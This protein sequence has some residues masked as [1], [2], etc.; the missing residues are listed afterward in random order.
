MLTV[1]DGYT[2]AD[3]KL[4]P[5]QYP[6]YRVDPVTN[7]PV[8]LEVIEFAAYCER[9]F[10]CVSAPVGIG[11]MLIAI[12]LAKLTGLRTCVVVPYKGL[13]K[14]YLDELAGHLTGIRG[15]SN[16]QCGDYAN[17]DCKSGAS[18]GCRY[19]S[20]NGVGGG[21]CEYER[22][23]E[24]ARNANVVVT[25]YDYWLNKN[26]HGGG[27][28]RKQTGED[29]GDANPFELLILDE[30]DEAEGKV[31][32]WLACR[33][34]ENEIKR[35]VKPQD[36]GDDIGVWR[37]FAKDHVE[38][39]TEDVRVAS[40]MLMQL[41]RK[42]T[43]QQVDGLHG[44][45]KLQGKLERIAGMQDDWV[46][47]ERI[48]TRWGR[49]WCFDVIWPGRYT[50]SSLFLGVPKVVIMSGTLTT[51]DL[52]LLGI[53]KD[54]YEY[55]QWSNIFPLS[56]QPTYL[57]PARKLNSEGK[58][59]GIRIDKHTSEED[60]RV[61]VEH[62]DV[63]IDA[64][65]DRKGLILTTSFEWQRYI[66]EHSRHSALMV[67]NTNDVDSDSA[68]E[69]FEKF[70]KLPAPRI[71]ISPSFNRGWNFSGDRAEYV[72]IPKCPFVPMQSKV[73]RARLERD[74]S[75]GDL[76][77]MKKVEQG[78]GR[79]KRG[80]D[81]R[82]VCV[83]MDGHFEYFL[84]KNKW[85]AQAWFVQSIRKVLSVPDAPEKL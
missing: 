42:A 15:R 56:K 9:R 35:W 18:M 52:A 46:L 39:V 36:I 5:A 40:A 51:K 14:Q 65:L 62:M 2:P 85:L 23:V 72:L 28:N 47:E 8:Q 84:Y 45:Q 49:M 34:Y 29:A 50:E 53:R 69:E 80:P 37:Q 10:A 76:L 7:S 48:G 4:D 44:L 11:K 81:E 82:A 73:M 71:M 1:L 59:V 22:A 83:L 78:N 67:G 55:M 25:N 24:Y 3:F 57:C 61:W 33:V 64:N 17:Q 75:Y 70:C 66:K 60:K 27:L 30:G 68:Q 58:W 77:C 26:A 79:V 54:Q 38:E 20:K 13:E 12:T 21:G 31:S 74:K 63:F 32:E 6:G 19:A 41:G 16:Y 43:K